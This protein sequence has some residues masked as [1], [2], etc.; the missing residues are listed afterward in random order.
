MILDKYKW[1]QGKNTRLWTAVAL[2]V[3]IAAGCWMLYKRLGELSLSYTTVQWVKTVVP[4]ATFTVLSLCVYMLVNKPSMADFMIAAEG[5]LKK[6]SFASRR[7]IIISTTIVII[8][9]ILMAVLLGVLDF[10][11]NLF[12]SNVIGI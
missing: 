6:V 12:F 4:L 8:T 9:V 3:V 11:F 2:E 1:G 7:E 5:E 10:V